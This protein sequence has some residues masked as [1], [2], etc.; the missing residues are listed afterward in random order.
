MT[1]KRRSRTWLVTDTHFNHQRMLKEQWRPADY[2]DRILKNWRRLVQPD[3]TVI[4]LGDVIIGQNGKLGEIVYSLPGIKVLVR[5]NHDQESDA[6]YRNRGFTWVCQGMVYG[7]VYFSHTPAVS[8][9]SGAELNVH[10]HLHDKT[11]HGTKLPAHC[12]L[13]AMEHTDYCPVLFEDFIGHYPNRE[14]ESKNYF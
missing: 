9:P 10:G 7:G 14:V 6:W 3:D 1:D 4:H 12:K 13:L 11:H 2:Q 8:L 5:G